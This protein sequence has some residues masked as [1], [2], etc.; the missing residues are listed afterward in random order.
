MSLSLSCPAPAGLAVL[1][2]VPKIPSEGA[3]VPPAA[4][5]LGG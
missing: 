2:A 3:A 1:R 4:P 5:G